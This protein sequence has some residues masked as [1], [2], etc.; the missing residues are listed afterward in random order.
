MNTDLTVKKDK[1]GSHEGY[2]IEFQ[3]YFLSEIMFNTTGI[4]YVLLG[5]VSRAMEGFINPLGNYIL[6]GKKDKITHP[7]FADYKHT[8]WDS[9]GLFKKVN[10]ILADNGKEMIVWDPKVWEEVKELPF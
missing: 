1:S 2:W 7:V 10:R 5:D 4:V 9:R 6:G 3:K 8:D